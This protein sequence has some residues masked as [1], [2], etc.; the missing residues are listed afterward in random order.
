MFLYLCDLAFTDEDGY[1]REDFLDCLG[2]SAR[3]DE[4]EETFAPYW[5][6]PLMD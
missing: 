4:E 2:F 5:E 1:V 3:E 6:E